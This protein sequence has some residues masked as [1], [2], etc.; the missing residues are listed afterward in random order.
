VSK[1]N[2]EFLTTEIFILDKQ[3]DSQIKRGTQIEDVINNINGYTKLNVSFVEGGAINSKY[4][5]NVK[6]SIFFMNQARELDNYLRKSILE[7]MSFYKNNKNF[8]LEI[9]KNNGILKFEIETSRLYI[10][11]I[12]L[13][14]FWN[15]FAYLLVSA[16]AI[17]FAKNQIKSI[18]SLKNFI[19]DFSFLEKENN[20]F[21][22]TGAKEIREM[23]R[24]FLNIINKM[25]YLLNSRTVMLAQISHDLRTP[26]TRM[27]LQTEFIGDKAM[28][29]FFK[30][31]LG[32]MEGL[33]N[34]Y[35][36]FAKGESDG[37]YTEINTKN[38][39]DNIIDDYKR[40]NYNNISISYSLNTKT[41][42]VRENAFKRAINNLINNSLKYSEKKIILSVKTI[43]QRLLVTIEDDG[44]GISEKDLKKIKK[45]FFTSEERIKQGVSGSGLGLSIAQQVVS[46]HRGD[47]KF[48]KSDKLGGLMVILTIPINNKKTKNVAKNKR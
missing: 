27:K 10:A 6:G 44:N 9:E 24:A 42:R 7:A 47:I 16:V 29:D 45:P 32:E 21:K 39:F 13:I 17:I 8:T 2:I 19:N 35:I 15:V 40:S 26:L 11:R 34:E 48:L 28:A 23:G 33:I 30:K 20:D 38:F 22:P 1:K 18:D 5:V 36:L 37:E 46:A 41:C 25:K 3:F 43:R 4:L 12:D 31:D 14:I